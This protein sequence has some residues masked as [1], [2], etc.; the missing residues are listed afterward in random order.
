[1]TTTEIAL[2]GRTYT[3]TT[4]GAEESREFVTIGSLTNS[5]GSFAGYVVQR[6]STGSLHIIGGPR[7]TA[8]V[9]RQVRQALAVLV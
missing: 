5:R 8:I 6:K 7:A 9:D 3:F 4:E 2:K 1:M